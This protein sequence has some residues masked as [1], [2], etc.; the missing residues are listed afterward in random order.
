MTTTAGPSEI[1]KSAHCATCGHRR[2]VVGWDK[3]GC[4]CFLL[5][6]AVPTFGV[7]LVLL[8]LLPLL[9]VGWRCTTCGSRKGLTAIE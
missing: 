5:L 2:A 9:P 1:M 7:S 3:S 8:L 6:A 4:G